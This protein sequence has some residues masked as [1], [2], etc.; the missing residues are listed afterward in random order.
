M[1]II[2]NIAVLALTAGLMAGCNKPT[3]PEPQPEQ[4]PVEAPPVETP[5]V[6]AEPEQPET[7]DMAVPKVD[8]EKA[9]EAYKV[10]H[11]ESMPTQDKQNRISA[12]MKDN[13]WDQDGYLALIYDITQDPVSR[14]YYV[15]L[16]QQ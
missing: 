11:D 15:D 1:K 2:N 14:A 10:L 5:P 3:T 9:A 16:L 6:A 12:L 4:A 7:P 13:G 8:V